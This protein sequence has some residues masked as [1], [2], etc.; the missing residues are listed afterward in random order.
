MAVLGSVTWSP[1]DPGIGDSVKVEVLNPQGTPYNN[2]DPTLI[3]VNGVPGSTQYL[4]FAN[5]GAHSLLV[6]ATGPAGPE[7]LTATIQVSAPPAAPVTAAPVT[8]DPLPG[9]AAQATT[10]PRIIA[11]SPGSESPYEILLS[12]LAPSAVVPPLPH[13]AAPAEPPVNVTPAITP[14]PAPVAAAPATAQATAPA[15]DPVAAPATNPAADQVR[16]LS[17]ATFPTVIENLPIRVAPPPTAPQTTYVWDFGD[18]SAQVTTTTP[19]VTHDFEAALGTTDLYQPFHI[20]VTMTDPSGTS[21]TSTRTLSAMNVYVASKNRGFLVPS[22][23][24]NGWLQ[25][26]AAGFAG[27]ATITNAESSAFQV[28]HYQIIPITADGADPGTVS[29]PIAVAQPVQVPAK[30]SVDI[31]V[32]G[33]DPSTVSSP[34]ALAQPV[35]VPARG[36]VDIQVSCDSSDLPGNAIGFSAVFVDPASVAAKFPEKVAARS[37]DPASPPASEPRADTAPQVPSDVAAPAAGAATSEGGTVTGPIPVESP[38]AGLQVRATAH[39]IMAPADRLSGESA[40][41]G[42]SAQVGQPCDPDN[43]GDAPADLVCQVVQPVQYKQV[44]L[45]GM[46]VNAR[47][48]DTVLV[49]GGGDSLVSGMLVALTPPQPFSHSGLM[50]ADY[51]QI[52]HCTASQERLMAYPVGDALTSSEPTD[53]FRSDVVEYV[54]PGVIT[55]SAEEATS[56][57][58]MNDPESGKSYSFGNEFS[59]FPNSIM[60]DGALQLIPPVVVKPDPLEETPA[61]RQQLWK[62]ADDAAQQAGQFHYRFYCFTDPAI[63]EG[64]TGNAPANVGWASGTSPAVCASF[65]WL[66]MKRNGMNLMGPSAN[67]TQAEV[68]SYA[69]ANGAAISADTPDGLFFYSAAQRQV[70]GAFLN[71]SLFNLVRDQVNWFEDDLTGTS[72]HICN[73]IC[74]SFADDDSSSDNDST[75]WQNPGSAN[76]VSPNDILFWNLPSAGGPY[77][78]FERLYYQP[79]QV[80]NVPVSVWARYSGTATV[81]GKVTYNGAPAP[82][83]TIQLTQTLTAFSGADG[84]FTIPGVPLGSYQLKAT[85]SEPSDIPGGLPWLASASQIVSVDQASQSVAVTLE[86]P[87]SAYREVDIESSVTLNWSYSWNDG[88]TTERQ[89]ETVGVSIS[90]DVG[91]DQPANSGSFNTSVHSAYFDYTATAVLAPG[92]AVNVTVVGTIDGDQNTQSVVSL[93]VGADQQTSFGYNGQWSAKNDSAT[94]SAVIITNGRQNREN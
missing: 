62:V 5:S 67:V 92:G 16:D 72:T 34:I 23:S 1:A 41:S 36:S 11:A 7:Q 14:S 70:A 79:S 50:T 51:L 8:A 58:T 76:A 60:L 15:S 4:Q 22:T 47:K 52:T 73:Q 32:A 91:P 55:E 59:Q 56:P 3:C 88:I 84:T 38:L 90:L 65:V 66:M 43:L 82:G 12:A 44:T 25:K 35:E 74:N 26:T 94:M 81:N 20:T 42:G 45:P 37:V 30:G 39:F 53:G 64:T 13:P 75:A 69:T 77:G 61:L 2:D 27:T 48:G 57:F 87:S 78:Y 24:A 10:L 86:P 29:S 18:G 19:Y 46:F 28:S 40:T 68:S 83:A 6:T 21:S 49:P 33:T 80:S 54:W 85:K 89:S 71:Q 31:R 93:L 17:V 63:A 9:A